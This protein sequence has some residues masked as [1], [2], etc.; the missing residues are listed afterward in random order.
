MLSPRTILSI[1]IF[2]P[3]LLPKNFFMIRSKHQLEHH[4]II[5]MHTAQEKKRAGKREKKEN[6]FYGFHFVVIIIV[7]AIIVTSNKIRIYSLNVLRVVMENVKKM[8]AEKEKPSSR[9]SNFSYL[10]LGILSVF[11]L[12][13]CRGETLA[14]PASPAE[15]NNFLIM[16][17]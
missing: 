16:I 7:F 4:I 9:R 10:T 8:L 15:R 11:E 3:L 12:H 5:I 1:I 13:P 14:S 17:N 2:A 6:H